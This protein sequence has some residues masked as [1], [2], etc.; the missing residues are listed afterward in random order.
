M[1][2]VCGQIIRLC[3]LGKTVFDSKSLSHPL[4]AIGSILKVY[5]TF[6]KIEDVDLP[7]LSSSLA[8]VNKNL[9]HGPFKTRWNAAKSCQNLFSNNNLVSNNYLKRDLLIISSSLQSC[10]FNCPNF[11]VKIQSCIALSLLVKNKALNIEISQASLSSLKCD[12][13]ESETGDDY[14]SILIQEVNSTPLFVLD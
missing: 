11:K 13:T 10:L 6:I 12:V 8:F 1:N 4:R 5:G 3:L 9:E 2:E 7:Q 14:K